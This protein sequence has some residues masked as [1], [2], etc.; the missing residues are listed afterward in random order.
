MT[1]SPSRGVVAARSSW[2]AVSPAPGRSSISG[3]PPPPGPGACGTGPGPPAKPGQLPPGQVRR[4][5]SAEAAWAALGGGLEVGGV[6]TF[7][8]IGVA[9]VEL[10]HPGGDP[11]QEMAVVGHEHQAAPEGGQPLLQPGHRPQVQMVGGSSRTSSSAGGPAPGP[12]PPVWPGLPTAWPRHRRPTSHAQALE[13]GHASHP[14]PMARSP[15]PGS[16]ALFRSPPGA[17][18]RRTTPSSGWS[19]PARLAARSTCRCR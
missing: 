9:A 2:S 17:P 3:W 7:V 6:A 13:G 5:A 11:V 8:H 12:A 15:C 1:L 10:H 19:T 16:S 18:S 4:L 14:S